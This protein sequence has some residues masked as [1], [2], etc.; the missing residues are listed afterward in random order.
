MIMRDFMDYNGAKLNHKILY[1][2]RKLISKVED[3]KDA[4]NVERST[5]SGVH[6]V[7]LLS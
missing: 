1:I 4:R 6:L 2:R 5:H 3:K 7:R